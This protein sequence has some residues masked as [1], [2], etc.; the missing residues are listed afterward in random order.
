MLLTAASLLIAATAIAQDAPKLDL[1]LDG[2][3]RSYPVFVRM[4]DQL[5]RKGGDYEAFC[6]EH[7]TTP[8]SRLRKQVLK[9]LRAKSDRSWSA[10]RTAVEALET[11]GAVHDLARFWIVNGFACEQRRQG[12]VRVGARAML[13]K[14]LPG[15]LVRICECDHARIHP[16]A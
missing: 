3:D 2:D 6:K 7:A 4:A 16:G 14:F 5:F 9:D 8:R 13:K 15:S 11:D 12:W 1:D 10:V